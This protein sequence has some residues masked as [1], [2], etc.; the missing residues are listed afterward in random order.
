MSYTKKDFGL[1][2]KDQITTG[3]DVVRV[4]RWAHQEFLDHCRELEAGLQPEMMRVIVMEEGPEFELTE[5]E[6]QSLADDLQSH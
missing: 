3:Y 1:R 2:L 6:I 5:H 4:A